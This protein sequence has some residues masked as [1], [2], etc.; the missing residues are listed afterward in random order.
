VL[1][2]ELALGACRSTTK[3]ELSHDAL[4]IPEAYCFSSLPMPLLP[5]NLAFLMPHQLLTAYPTDLNPYHKSSAK[6]VCT[7][8][9]EVI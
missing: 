8:G 9:V 4:T 1:F 6:A 7:L 2:V 5:R 3:N